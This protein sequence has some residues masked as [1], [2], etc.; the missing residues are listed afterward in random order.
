MT[1]RVDLALSPRLDGLGAIKR[2][3]EA[4]MAKGQAVLLHAPVSDDTYRRLPDLVRW[5]DDRLSGIAGIAFAMDE[6]GVVSD[7]P[8]FTPWWEATLHACEAR[9]LGYQVEAPLP[10]A[11]GPG[12]S[13]PRPAPRPEPHPELL[14]T[15]PVDSEE[16]HQATLVA[17][18]EGVGTLA[19]F[20]NLPRLTDGHPKLLAYVAQ[21]PRD[22]A[23][24]E[25]HRASSRL[26]TLIH[27]TEGV[28]AG[29]VTALKELC[30][31]L[32]SEVSVGESPEAVSEVTARIVLSRVCVDTYRSVTEQTLSPWPE[33]LRQEALSTLV[34]DW[35]RKSPPATWHAALNADLWL[36]E[37]PALGVIAAGG[38]PVPLDRF[39]I[40]ALEITSHTPRWFESAREAKSPW[41]APEA[42]VPGGVLPLSVLDRPRPR[43]R[44]KP[45]TILGIASTTLANHAAVV[46]RDGEVLSAVQEE[47]PRRRKQLGWHPPGEPGVTVVSDATLPLEASWPKRAIASA[48]EIAGL[49][50]A[51]VDHL[52]YNGIP[53]RYF[54]TYSL[55][56]PSHPPRTL[57]DGR[58][59]SIPHHLAHAASAFRVSGMEDAFIFTVDGRGE[60]ET[61][62]FF[63]VEQGAIRRVFDVMV[64]EDSLI[65][66]VYEYLTTILGFGHYG[67]G[68]TMGLAPYGEPTVD[69]S[70]WLSARTR[71]DF[72]IHD[73]GLDGPFGHLKRKRGGPM[74][75]AHKNLA[76]SAQRALEETVLAFVRDGVA[77]RPLPRLCLAGGVAL[78]C[79]MNQR[80][81]VEF[82]V[83]E[84][85][86]Q[87]AANDAG[88]ALGA[89]AEA[90]WELTGENLAPMTHAKLGTGYSPAQ[91]RAALE[92]FG[93]SYTLPEDLAEVV[94][95]RLVNQEVIAWFDGRMEFGP[96]ALGGRSILADPRTQ[97]M[98][99]RVNRHKAR[100]LWRPFGPSVLAGH[101]ADWF[102][103][104]FHSPFMLFTLPVRP[105]RRDQIA[106]VVHVDGT[107]RPQ[108][109]SA[110]DNPRYHALIS[111]FHRL[112]GV[113]MVLNT[114][115]NTAF[116]PIVQSPED[117]IST[118]LQLGVDA[119]VIEGHLVERPAV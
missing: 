119:L 54:P 27:A 98:Q 52:A 116:E 72:S 20:V 107:T 85:Y 80:L 89:A 28:D 43:R 21:D 82:G 95:Q 49:T 59:C 86:V 113:P 93:L 15:W 6:S 118:F 105:E 12:L 30:E 108:S 19:R 88:T 96:R 5:I 4:A 77:G 16:S 66:G 109:V 11:P 14:T 56:E 9:E 84:I 115:F 97:A 67:A 41:L 111:A 76:A 112:T 8:D 22:M 91:V 39:L 102:E 62:A 110:S 51:E 47:R 63:A 7:A 103:T 64:G 74:T 87:P 48:L 33:G 40:E 13:P 32:G 60:R 26:N 78:N 2:A 81:R 117:A 37:V 106:A 79:A 101:E 94:A 17:L 73:R 1:R 10:G 29:L 70:P 34:Q 36:V 71:S 100:Q 46:V 31:G 35:Q 90:H 55:S 42:V 18:L 44:A 104:P 68:S 50:M 61:A 92:R 83:D 99:D 23:R 114:S 75:Q 57:F 53:A 69:L 58:D 3:A 38:D 24:L 65:G 45:L 25:R